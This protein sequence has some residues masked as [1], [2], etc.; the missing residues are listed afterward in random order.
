M[1]NPTLRALRT[2]IRTG[3]KALKEVYGS[4][5]YGIKTGLNAAFV[6]D[7][8]TKER[9]CAEDPRSAELLKPLLKGNELTRWRVESQGNWILY[10]PKNRIDIDRYPAIRDW[11]FP[12]KEQLEKRATKQEWFELQQAQELMFRHLRHRK[13]PI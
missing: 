11:L 4:P 13:L 6:I 10:I 5:L 3:R 8:P 1:E 7:M 9:L 12:F 2:K